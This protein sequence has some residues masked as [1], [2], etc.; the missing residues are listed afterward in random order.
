MTP[1][2]DTSQIPERASLPEVVRLGRWVVVF[3]LGSTTDLLDHSGTG[4][5]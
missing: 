4:R 2:T 5:A 3:A 1:E